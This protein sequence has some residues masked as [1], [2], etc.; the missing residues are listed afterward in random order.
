MSIDKSITHISTNR[1]ISITSKVS[2]TD[3]SQATIDLLYV[4]IDEIFVTYM[5]SFNM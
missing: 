1:I 2:L 3:P 4:T 5:Q